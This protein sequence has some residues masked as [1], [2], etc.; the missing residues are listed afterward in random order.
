MITN[1]LIIL[2]NRRHLSVGWY[3]TNVSSYTVKMI[4]SPWNRNPFLFSESQ[5]SKQR[6]QL[7]MSIN[8]FFGDNK[9]SPW[10]GTLGQVK[11]FYVSRCHF[12]ETI[13]KPTLRSHR[14]LPPWE[15]FLGCAILTKSFLF[16]LFSKIKLVYLKYH[17]QYPFI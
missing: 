11:L 15:V 13:K 1:Y 10:N 6:D 3:A 8:T 14:I 7:L 5:L 2:F 16:N 9:I 4:F 17:K 12:S